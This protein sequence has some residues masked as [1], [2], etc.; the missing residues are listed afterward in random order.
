MLTVISTTEF[1]PAGYIE[2]DALPASRMGETARRVNRV[3]T[4]DGGAVVNDAGYSESDRTIDLR[5]Q[6]GSATF[7]ASIARL[8]ETYQQ[9]QIAN[10]HGVYLAVPET[11]RAAPP[12]SQL[13]L[14]VLRKLSD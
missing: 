7:E 13:R 2:I 10:R 14:L 8:V 12:E 5:W 4:L 3:A 11:Y 6:Q 9:I 1:D